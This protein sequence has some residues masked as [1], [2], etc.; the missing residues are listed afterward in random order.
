M[1]E[2][3]KNA[4]S[5]V[6]YAASK[7]LAER[8]AWQLMKEQDPQFDLVTILPSFLWGVRTV[9]VAASNELTS[10]FSANHQRDYCRHQRLERTY[11]WP[12][13]E[14]K[15]RELQRRETTR[16]IAVC[17]CARCSQASRRCS[18]FASCWRPA[19]HRLCRDSYHT[20]DL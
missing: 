19:Y 5:F 15:A 10:S 11:S 6:K 20:A 2:Y 3:G 8:A 16:R 4:P 1:Q 18:R 12:P 14:G 17:R 13:Q 9:F 7:T